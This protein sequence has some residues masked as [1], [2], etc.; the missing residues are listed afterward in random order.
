MNLYHGVDILEVN[1]LDTFLHELHTPT[2]TSYISCEEF[3]DNVY[4]L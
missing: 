1:L 2:E 3:E 4:G